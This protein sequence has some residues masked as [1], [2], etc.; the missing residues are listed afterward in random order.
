MNL[1]NDLT[2][3]AFVVANILDTT[4]APSTIAEL[5][6]YVT[7][8]YV[9]RHYEGKEKIVSIKAFSAIPCRDS[10]FRENLRKTTDSQENFDQYLRLAFCPN[11]TKADV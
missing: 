7:P 2:F 10:I 5:Y 1:L 6:Q 8:R 3:P 9:F 11:M 4:K